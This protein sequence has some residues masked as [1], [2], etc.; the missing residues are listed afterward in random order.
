MY[1]NPICNRVKSLMLSFPSYCYLAFLSLYFMLLIQMQFICSSSEPYENP[2]WIAVH[3]GIVF[4]RCEE[5]NYTLMWRD[6][7]AVVQG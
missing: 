1:L 4:I 6:D 5:S 3:S 7:L 2:T